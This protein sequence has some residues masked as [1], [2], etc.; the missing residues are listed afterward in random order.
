ML[1]NIDNYIQQMIAMLCVFE[2]TIIIYFYI[3]IYHMFAN[4]I[5]SNECLMLQIE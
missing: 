5:K 4:L 2:N 3:Y 1:F